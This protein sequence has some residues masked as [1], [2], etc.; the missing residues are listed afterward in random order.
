[1][2]ALRV[3][4]ET[5]TASEEDILAHLRECNASFIPPLEMNVNVQEYSKKV[6]QHSVTFEAWDDQ[7]LV[8]LVAGYFNDM[9][10]LIGYITDVSVANMYAGKGIASELLRLSIAYGTL[11][12]FKEMRLRVS[13]QNLRAIALYKKFGFQEFRSDD[14]FIEMK[15]ELTK[16]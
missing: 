2:I 7:K 4:Y 9:K 11:Q 1:M 16:G 13:R 5:K 14:D 15:L 10:S 6:F 12:S 3:R 8:G